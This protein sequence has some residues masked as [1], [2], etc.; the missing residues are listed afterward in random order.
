MRTA[1]KSDS[2]LSVRAFA[3]THVVL[4][5][6]DITPEKRK[7]L[8]GFA[9]HRTD[10]D[11]DRA[12][13]LQG[14][15]F[16]PN[17]RGDAGEQGGTDQFPIQKFRWGDYTATPTHHYTYRVSAMY[18]KP[19]DLKPGPTVSVD[20]Q[21][22][23]PSNVGGG[24]HQVHFNRSAAASQAYVRRFGDVSPELVPGKAAFTW[25][26]R[27]LEES[28]VAF[29]ERAVDATWA[30]Y[31]NVYEFQK[32]NFLEALKDAG[33]RGVTL[34]IMFDAI[35][36]ASGPRQKNLSAIAK[37]NIA[38]KY[39]KPREHLASISH[40][41]FMVLC[42]NGQPV[43]VW[44][45]STNFT[46]GG[47]YGQA[48]VGHAV[49]DSALAA[50]YLALHKALWNGTAP[51]PG[52]AASRTIA[53]QLSPVPPGGKPAIYP[54]FSPRTGTVAIATCK[55]LIDHAHDLVCIT[56]PFQL[57]ADLD[58]ALSDA[59][60]AFLKFALL[61]TSGTVV[62]A[63][64][65]D[66][67]NRVAAAAR[68]KTKLDQFQQESLHHTGV[69]IHTKYILVDPLSDVPTVVTGSANFSTNSCINN[70]ENQL[71]ISGNTAVADVYL[72]EFMR[73]FDHYM[74]RDLMARAK[75][76]PKIL[77]LAEDDSWTAKYFAGGP[78]ERD[79]KAFSS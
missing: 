36:K 38:Q 43:A 12:D 17:H 63:V 47:I 1:R 45:G 31:L 57:H 2:G 28:L 42:H 58:A 51:D 78:E 4:L 39:L 46:D 18:G 69:Y 66:T 68:L 53:E 37:H 27:G 23:D 49:E 5:G 33:K 59:K 77:A 25:L 41:K 75:K 74:F 13:W 60:N 48:N 65:R 52:L 71:V 21:T 40:D 6:F 22:E 7:G 15:L 50:K 19:G 55:N 44:T 3:G 24:P 9:I 29:I 34:E 32:D 72:G 54:I 11:A 20:V 73:M 76:Q 64:H 30:L 67:D 35:K 62:E 61:N 8:L 56:V 10:K 16:F 26:S 70:D 14:M 79:R